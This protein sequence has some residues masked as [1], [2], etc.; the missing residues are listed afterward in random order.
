MGQTQI[1]TKGPCPLEP[2]HAPCGAFGHLY[3]PEAFHVNYGSYLYLDMYWTPRFS[4]IGVHRRQT[5]G[6]HGSRLAVSPSPVVTHAYA[7]TSTRTR[8]GREAFKQTWTDD[9]CAVSLG[10]SPVPRR[11]EAHLT[12]WN[13]DYLGCCAMDDRRSQRRMLPIEAGL[14]NAVLPT[15]RNR[16]GRRQKR[17]RRSIQAFRP[18]ASDNLHGKEQ[19]ALEPIHLT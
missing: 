13:R 8:Y 1:R 10:C 2:G 16:T 3:V 9:D 6:E 17:W 18:D 19:R 15:S 5:P 4:T 14:A 7:V 11:L 12:G